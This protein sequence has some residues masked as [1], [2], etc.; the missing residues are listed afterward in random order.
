MELRV[1]WSDF[2]T[3]PATLKVTA[4]KLS[5]SIKHCF[6]IYSDDISNVWNKLPDNMHSLK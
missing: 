1:L 2:P 3:S 5:D 4:K 6:D